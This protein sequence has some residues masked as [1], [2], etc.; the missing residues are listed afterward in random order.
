VIGMTNRKDLIDEAVL[1]PGRLEVHIEIG[2]P[3]EEGRIQILKIHTKQL[4]EEGLLDK[5]VSL[6][7]IARVA[8]N[9]TGAEL[10]AVIKNASSYAMTKGN[11]LMDFSKQ[12][13]IKEGTKV[14]MTDLLRSLEEVVPGFGL[15]QENFDVYTRT[16][17]INYGPNFDKIMAMLGKVSSLALSGP[18]QLTSLLLFGPQGSGK[19]SIAAHFARQSNFTYVKIITPERFLGVGT[20]GRINSITKIFNDAYKAKESLIILDNLERLV[21]Y[22]QTGPEFNNTLMQALLVLVKRIPTN[23]DCRLLVVGTSSNYAAIDLLDIDKVFTV[24]QKVPLLKREEAAKVLEA[25]LGIENVAIKKLMNF[26]EICKD[27]PKSLWG[28][29]WAKYSS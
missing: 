10:E 23:P 17:L 28:N 27:K 15:D 14:N 24:K 26:K 1:R 3:S 19:T 18:K 13:T 2:I 11:N 8:K 4:Q 9:Y 5:G 12:L 25:D 21:E 16:R 20:Y 7:E 29:L 22:V 6:S